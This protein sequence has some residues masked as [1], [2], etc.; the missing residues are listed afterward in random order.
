V[1]EAESFAQLLVSFLPALRRY[2]RALARDPDVAADLVQAVFLRALERRSGFAGGTDLEAWLITMARNLYRTG[3]RVRLLHLLRD[4]EYCHL[5]HGPAPPNQLDRL[6]LGDVDRALATLP[7]RQ[8]EMVLLVALSG[9]RG[10][11]L[12]R[13]AG[14]S[15]QAAWH[16]LT[17][18]R[19]RLRR[20]CA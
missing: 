8:R 19:D 15:H 9:L 14:T 18:G 1:S 20:L 6:A 7:R 3:E 13:A 5:R 2:G 12:A 4:G 16:R 10:K 11:R 17:R